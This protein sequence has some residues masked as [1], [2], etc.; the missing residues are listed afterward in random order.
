MASFDG[1]HATNN[2][3]EFDVT[4][5]ARDIMVRGKQDTGLCFVEVETGT[6]N[7]FKGQEITGSGYLW[8]SVEYT[9]NNEITKLDYTTMT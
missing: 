1:A 6:A 7:Y 2:Q 3:I 8:I 4:K 9:C 5:W